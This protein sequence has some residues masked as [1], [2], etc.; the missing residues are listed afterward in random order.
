MKILI[1]GGSGYLGKL[2]IESLLQRQ[3][4]K[5]VVN[6]DRNKLSFPSEKYHYLSVNEWEKEIEKFGKFDIVL[7]L[8]YSIR[9]PFRDKDLEKWAYENISISEAIANFSIKN[10]VKKFIHFSTVALYG[11]RKENNLQN[12]FREDSILNL[13]GYDYADNKLEI[14]RRLLNTWESNKEARTKLIILRIASVTGPIGQK[15]ETK[16]GLITFLK[17]KLPF[18]IYVR[19]DSGRQYLHENDLVSAVEF[20]INNKKMRKKIEIFNLAPRDF[21]TFKEMARLQK[22]FAIKVPYRIL[23][24]IF[25]VIWKISRGRIPTAPGAINSFSYPIY[26]DGS[27][28]EKAGFNY[29]FSSKDAFK[30]KK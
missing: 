28:I 2:L 6:I 22:K 8:A 20:L 16:K 19:E 21:L 17:S 27:K 9:R 23:R 25:S 14:E 4:V 13:T 18:L 1:T 11:A 30:A 12:K 15:L 5:L 29:K 3:E 26:V 24:F 10:G 7:N